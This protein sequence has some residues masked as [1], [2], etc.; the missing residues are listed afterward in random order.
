M[1]ANLDILIAGARKRLTDLKRPGVR[2]A[3][4][5]AAELHSPRGFRE[6]LLRAASETPAIIAELKQ[7]SPSKG[8][9]RE[10]MHVGALASDLVRNGATAL[11]VLTEEEYFEGSLA[12]L[13]EASAATEVPCLR[14]DFIVDELQVVEAR[15]NRADAI[16]VIVAALTDKELR[17][18]R[19]RAFDW[20]LDVLCEVHDSEEL[21]RAVNLGF[22]LLGVNSRNLKTFEVSLD[23]AA[24]LAEQLPIDAVRVAESGIRNGEDIRRLRAVGYHAFL[25]GET[26]MK[27]ERPG[28]A[29]SAL[30]A[31]SMAGPVR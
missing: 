25:V 13:R 11:S 21:T 6:K 14:K 31:D 28:E 9:I 10:S 2:G 1:T 8:R 5:H 17:A 20:D 19:E 4:E 24:R 12:N 18:L 27:A 3:L 7:A 30:L 16:L 22:D 26:L 29:L 15:A 23:T